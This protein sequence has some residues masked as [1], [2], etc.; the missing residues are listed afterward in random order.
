MRKL[1]VFFRIGYD[2]F[3]KK[4]QPSCNKV[5]YRAAPAHKRSQERQELGHWEG[6]TVVSRQSKVAIA[7]IDS[8]D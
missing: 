6:D 7:V 2:V 5:K 1:S 3:E 4:N 8:L